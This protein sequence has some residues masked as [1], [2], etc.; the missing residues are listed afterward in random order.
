M[1]DE[2]EELEQ[3][4]GDDIY[5]EIYPFWDG[6]DDFFNI[7]KVDDV[8]LLPNLK[9]VV[10]FHHDGEHRQTH[11]RQTSWLGW[12]MKRVPCALFYTIYQ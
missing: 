4:G 3:E 7:K 12:F 10:L 8:K 6:E 1:L 9:S 5:A 2:I 11:Y